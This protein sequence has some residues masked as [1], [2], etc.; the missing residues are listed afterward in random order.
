MKLIHS[1]SLR[2]KDSL[3]LSLSRKKR[4]MRDKGQ[5]RQEQ[6]ILISQERTMNM[7]ISVTY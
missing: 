1:S 3:F 4:S 5:E 6:G 2:G 7:D